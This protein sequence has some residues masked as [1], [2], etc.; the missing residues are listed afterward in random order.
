MKSTNENISRILLPRNLQR[1]LTKWLVKL[2]LGEVASA[3]KAGEMSHLT[4]GSR[5]KHGAAM[6]EHKR[7]DA[8]ERDR[9]QV[10]SSFS[11]EK[12]PSTHACQAFVGSRPLD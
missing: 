4:V 6:S 10:R 12:W 7:P 8:E 9:G 3:I 5:M 1:K 11:Q 2:R